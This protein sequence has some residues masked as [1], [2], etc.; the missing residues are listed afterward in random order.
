MSEIKW[1]MTEC[2][3]TSPYSAGTQLLLLDD[4][5]G[6]CIVMIQVIY[7]KHIKICGAVGLL[8]V[9]NADMFTGFILPST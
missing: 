2:L 1:Y 8:H 9:K 7:I 6:L 5:Y 4:L 3:N